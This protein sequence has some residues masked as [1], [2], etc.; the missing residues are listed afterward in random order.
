M[1]VPIACQLGLLLFSGVSL[2]VFLSDIRHMKIN[3]EL[4]FILLIG[5]LILGPICGFNLETL[6]GDGLIALCVLTV[7]FIL[8]ML[9]AIGAG[10]AKFAAV[11][12]LWLGADLVVEY[13]I[14]A[15]I[16]GSVLALSFLALRRIPLPQSLACKPWISRLHDDGAQIPYG[17]ALSSAGL[18]T[19]AQT[20][21]AASLQF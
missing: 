5:Y 13:V 18:I 19:I 7:A 15:S 9:G 8:F 17:V 11:S 21:W 20:H 2:A 1:S 4:I 16:L 14:I 6:A 12:V 3:N 10:D